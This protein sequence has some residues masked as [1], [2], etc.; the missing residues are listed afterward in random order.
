MTSPYA[1]S[2]TVGVLGVRSS[3]LPT[4]EILDRP[5]ESYINDGPAGGA[6]AGVRVSMGAPAPVDL[7]VA[8]A[9]SSI[10]LHLALR[11]MTGNDTNPASFPQGVRRIGLILA[12]RFAASPGAL[13]I[14]FDAG[15]S[16]DLPDDRAVPREGCAVFVDRIREIHAGSDDDYQYQTSYTAIHEL[17][18]VFNLW[19]VNQESFLKERDSPEE[20]FKTLDF[21]DEHWKYLAHATDDMTLSRFVRPGGSRFGERGTLSHVHDVGSEDAV[22]VG[23]RGARTLKLEIHESQGEFYR[24]EPVELDVTL[25]STSARAVTVPD[26]ID[27]GYPRFNVWIT[28]PTGERRRYR[29]PNH[30]CE[31]FR[32]PLRIAKGRPFHRDVSIFGQSGGYTFREAGEHRIV[33][34]LRLDDGTVLRS[35]ERRVNVLAATDGS[36]RHD[37]FRDT[38]TRPATAR[39]LYYRAGVV[40]RP[41]AERV[42]DFAR[43]HASAAAAA[44]VYYALGRAMLK[45]ALRRRGKAAARA[46]GVAL[47]YLR[48]AL[49]HPRMTGHRCR[50]AEE[51]FRRHG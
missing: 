32:P 27:A 1:V 51:L 25:S 2:C 46:K 26:E 36:K 24:F 37:A 8:D 29:P 9:V 30:Y 28:S 3:P 19:H 4:L 7:A 50:K 20:M 10:D 31:T 23:R 11:Q 13:G 16:G 22:S 6:G 14:M 15:F 21:A 35:N 33:A 38:L 34:T 12:N 42:T 45:A 43:K 5:I 39:L 17:G 40:G 48:R 18:H 41:L 49:D 44:G 47:D